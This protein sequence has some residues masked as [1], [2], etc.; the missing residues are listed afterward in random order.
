MGTRRR[1]ALW[2]RRGREYVVRP[3]GWH[4]LVELVFCTKTDMIE[5]AHSAR[6][7]LRDNT[8]AH[9]VWRA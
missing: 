3:A 7:V 4:K 9:P 1:V 8:A 2:H 5:W 6:M